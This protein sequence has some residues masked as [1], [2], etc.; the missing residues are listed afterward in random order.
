MYMHVTSIVCFTLYIVEM[1]HVQ[2]CIEKRTYDK[3]R[4]RALFMEMY[5]LHVYLKKIKII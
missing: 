5:S 3:D 4:H 1:M 2:S